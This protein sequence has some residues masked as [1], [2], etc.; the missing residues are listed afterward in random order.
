MHGHMNVHRKEFGKLVHLLIFIIKK[1]I[2]MH[3][4]MNVKNCNLVGQC[5][6][7]DHLIYVLLDDSTAGIETCRSP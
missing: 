3:G 5:F 4:H 7:Q 1:F 2:T 6:I